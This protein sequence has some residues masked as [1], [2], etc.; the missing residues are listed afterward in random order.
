MN[1]SRA[2]N[3]ENVKFCWQ[4]VKQEL[5]SDYFVDQFYENLFGQF[6]ETRAAFSDNMALQKSKLLTMLDNVINGIEFIDQLEDELVNLGQLHLDKNISAEM[7]DIFVQN[8][9]ETASKAANHSLSN[10]ELEDWQNA[11]RLVSDIM[12]RAY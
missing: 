10:D 1:T 9:T 11:F 7:Y 6:P 3:P 5:G 2:I 8:I 12:L 4:K